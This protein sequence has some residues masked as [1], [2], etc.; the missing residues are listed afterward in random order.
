ML[1]HERISIVIRF[2]LRS[3]T[4][5]TRVEIHYVMQTEHKTVALWLVDCIYLACALR[6][7]ATQFDV[8]TIA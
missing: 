5:R 4:L 3:L 6:T 8:A 7:N 2:A 1:A